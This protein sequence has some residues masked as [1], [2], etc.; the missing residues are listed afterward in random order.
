[1]TVHEWM[2]FF[3]GWFA[4]ITCIGLWVWIGLRK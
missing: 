4:G 2:I 1:M 3:A